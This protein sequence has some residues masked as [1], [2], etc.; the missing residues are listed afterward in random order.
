MWQW[1]MD[2]VSLMKEKLAEGF[3]WV[4]RGLYEDMLTFH[5]KPIEVFMMGDWCSAGGEGDYFETREP[6]LPHLRNG[7]YIDMA[8]IVTENQ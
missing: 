8:A 2:E 6:L 5:R 1:T 4:S 7:Q 3:R